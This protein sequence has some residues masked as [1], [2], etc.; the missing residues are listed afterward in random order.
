MLG[1]KDYCVELL[2]C[3]NAQSKTCW[4]KCPPQLFFFLKSNL[5]KNYLDQVTKSNNVPA[6]SS[7][8]NDMVLSD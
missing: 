2:K 6:N 5:T 4:L 7:I 1:V 3:A 8:E